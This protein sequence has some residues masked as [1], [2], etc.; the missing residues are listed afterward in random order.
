MD[1]ANPRLVPLGRPDALDHRGESFPANLKRECHW[2][3]GL[4]DCNPA[5]GRSQHVGVCGQAEVLPYD[6]AMAKMILR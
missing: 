4:V 1:H 5:T 2:A 3:L 6:I